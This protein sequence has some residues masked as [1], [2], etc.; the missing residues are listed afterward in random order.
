M[1]KRIWEIDA[2]RGLCVLG[3]IAVH[4]VYDLTQLYGVFSWNAAWFSFVQNWG[5]VLFLLISG[6]SA[7][8]GS[9]SVRRGAVVFACGMLCTAVTYALYRIGLANSGIII[10]F[11]VLH[12]L[13]ICMIL[14]QAVKK[15]PTA[16]LTALGAVLTA[17]GLYL[18][19]KVFSFRFLMPLGFVYAGFQS[20]DY[21]PLIQNFGF[22]LLG[23]ALGRTLYR[24]R[25][26]RLPNVNE[27]IPPLRFLRACGK[28]S[29]AIYLIHQPAIAA[30]GIALAFLKRY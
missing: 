27:N 2:V 11:G 6:T 7:T 23:A 18:R 3:M 28:H 15:L 9:K 22:F 10:R 20:S 26:T 30:I 13:G 12:C 8:L 19:T 25:Q 5:G 29:L 1:K 17:L 4:L 14:W 24:E 16:H 21:F